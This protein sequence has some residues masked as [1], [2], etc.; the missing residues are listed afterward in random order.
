MGFGYGIRGWE[1]IVKCEGGLRMGLELRLRLGGGE[2][3]LGI[4]IEGVDEFNFV[5]LVG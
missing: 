5:F 4:W 2:I 3:W 1:I